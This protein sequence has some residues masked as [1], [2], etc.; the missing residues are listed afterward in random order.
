HLVSA[1]LMSAAYLLTHFEPLLLAMVLVQID[2]LH[3][4]FPLF[5]L[6]GYYVASDL[7]GV[8]DL[9]MRMRPM[10]ASFIPGRP[11]H[12]QVKAL[13]PWARYA[14]ATWV[15]L[16]LAVLRFLSVLLITAFPRR[17]APA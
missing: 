17:L 4:F 11:L 13:R 15:L 9:F 3:Q 6:D 8:P 7:I 16:T 2:A 5:R 1:G 12:P 14:V 10:L